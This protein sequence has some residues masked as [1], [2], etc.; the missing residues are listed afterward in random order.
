M[1]VTA[2]GSR[3]VII[4]LTYRSTF[5]IVLQE[6]DVLNKVQFSDYHHQLYGIEVFLT[7]EASGQV[8]F[9]FYS[10]VKLFA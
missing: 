1:S 7:A 10:G 4:A 9:R 5:M 8:R 6:P 2:G 3:P